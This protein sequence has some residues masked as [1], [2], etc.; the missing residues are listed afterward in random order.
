MNIKIVSAAE[1]LSLFSGLENK[2][3]V[4][5]SSDGKIISF[6]LQNVIYFNEESQSKLYAILCREKEDAHPRLAAIWWC[7]IDPRRSLDDISVFV[8]LT[9]ALFGV[10][11]TI[12]E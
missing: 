11:F 5:V 2:Y 9:I 6:D 10:N 4:L 3:N 8:Q 12:P 1:A 7:H